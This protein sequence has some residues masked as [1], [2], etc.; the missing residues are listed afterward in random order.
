L[1]AGRGIDEPDHPSAH[2]IVTIVVCPSTGWQVR[3]NILSIENKY[4]T[5]L[6]P[7]LAKPMVVDGTPIPPA[8]FKAPETSAS[9]IVALGHTHAK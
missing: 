2:Q 5:A 4:S 9:Q 3:K 7:N 1:L 8:D 6:H